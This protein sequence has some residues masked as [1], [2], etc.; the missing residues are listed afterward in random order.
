[1]QTIINQVAKMYADTEE[2]H[3]ELKHYIDMT[4]HR[5]WKVHQSFLI[6]MG[7]LMADAVLS[8]KF[9]KKTEHNKLVDI[10][11]YGKVNEILRFLLN[12]TLPMQKQARLRKHNQNMGVSKPQATKEVRNG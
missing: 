4:K 7:S 12:P 11:A 6:N 5:G 2:G 3:E 9:R 10:E 8:K 1:M